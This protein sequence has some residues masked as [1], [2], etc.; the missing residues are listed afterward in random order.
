MRSARI[1]GGMIATLAFVSSASAQTVL[2][3]AT[4]N[5]PQAEVRCGPSDKPEMYP[6]N[7]LKQG[8]RVQVVKEADG[9]WLAIVPPHGSFSW[10]NTRCLEEVGKATWMVRMPDGEKVPVLYGTSLRS[11]KPTV[12]SAELVKGSQVVALES[13]RT[14]D[15][16]KWLPIEPPSTEVRYIRAA[17]VARVPAPAIAGGPPPSSGD[18]PSFTAKAVD[19]SSSTTERPPTVSALKPPTTEGNGNSRW[20]EA[21]QAEQAGNIDQAI[22]LYDELGK[23]MANTDHDLAMQCFNKAYWLRQRNGRTVVAAY[24]AGNT[25]QSRIYPVPAAT[26]N[27]SVTCYVPQPACP[28]D[29]H[30][31][32]GRLRLA[33]RSLDYKRTYAIDD[34]QGG[35]L[36]A[37]VTAQPGVN[38][39]GFCG[40]NVEVSGSGCYRADVRANYLTACRVSPLP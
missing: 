38:L 36:L 21:Q 26:V 4:V 8:D 12:R 16:G 14:T 34:S 5:V 40:H 25:A 24:Q 31:L 1:L 18:T 2:Y 27:H 37:Y 29:Q 23:S 17:E 30:T 35:Y 15:D 33:G 19:S 28:Q 7:N 6:T 20:L 11:E 9:G 3:T 32:R 39:D 13:P 22:R 10:I